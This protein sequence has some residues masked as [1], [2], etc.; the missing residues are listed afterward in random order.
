MG[1]KVFDR[2]HRNK[3]ILLIVIAAIVTILITILIIF[4]PNIFI[5]DNNG[6]GS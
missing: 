4:S 5:P 3:S 1:L 6:G 2:E